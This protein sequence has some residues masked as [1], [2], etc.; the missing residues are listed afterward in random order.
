MVVQEKGLGLEA[1]PDK[2]SKILSLER[3]EELGT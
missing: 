2:A 3:N 1:R